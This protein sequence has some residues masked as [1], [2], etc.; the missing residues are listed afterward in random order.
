MSFARRTLAVLAAGFTAASLGLANPVAAQADPATPGTYP[1]ASSATRVLAGFFDT[2]TAPSLAALA[3]WKG[4]KAPFQGVNVYFGGRNRGCQQPNLTASWVGSATAA[5]WALVPTYFGDQP[6]CVYGTK[7]YR[8]TASN[9]AAQGRSDGTDAV[10][11]ARALGLLPGSALYADVEHYNRATAG[12]TAAV[13]TYVSEW[14]RTLHRSGYLAGIYAHQDSGVRDLAASYTSTTLARPDA[15]W[16]ARWDNWASTYNWP[17]AGNALWSE[18][19]RAKQYRGD[20]NET[21][22]GVT[23]NID[24]D[25]IRGPVATVARTYRSTASGALNVRSGPSSGYPIVGSVAGGAAIS[26]VCQARGQT[27]GSTAVWDRLTNGGFVSDR[28]VSTPSSTTWSPPLPIC[29]YPGQLTITTPVN[30]RSGPGTGYAVNG[31]VN[32]GGLAYVACQ[33]SGTRVGTTSVWNQLVDGRWLS[34]YYVSNASN[35]T[36][37]SPVPR[38]P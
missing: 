23:L 11:K 21:W 33:K 32:G 12:C 31:S 38:C 37:S 9:A 6:F 24:S 19:Q 17:T 5:G 14:T 2:C 28:Y 30:T 22:G 4:A 34:D 7:P 13:R 20:H 3:S 16:M 27:V 18:W 26:V 8:F 15:I 10:S 36:Y 25:L 29:S 1:A 35:T